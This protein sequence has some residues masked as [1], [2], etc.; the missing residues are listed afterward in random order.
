[1]ERLLIGF[2]MRLSGNLDSASQ[3]TTTSSSFYTL[4]R[5]PTMHTNGIQK[6][7]RG[8]AAEGRFG[9]LSCSTDGRD[10]AFWATHLTRY[11]VY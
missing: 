4:Y 11:V 10:L 8:L 2:S 3:I 5:I 1:M 9:N 6:H 7:A